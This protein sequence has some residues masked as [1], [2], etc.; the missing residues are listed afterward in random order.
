[1]PRAR[2]LQAGA[3]TRTDPV[4]SRWIVQN[5]LH[6]DRTT[7]VWSASDHAL[8]WCRDFAVHLAAGQPFGTV[9]PPRP[10]RVAFC[11]VRDDVQ[12]DLVRL[13]EQTGLT[14]A[15]R[16]A[17]HRIRFAPWGELAEPT[18]L[19]RV[20]R[21]NNSEVL[22]AECGR[23]ALAAVR[24]WLGDLSL[25]IITPCGDPLPDDAT[26]IILRLADDGKTFQIS[27]AQNGK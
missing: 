7:H 8:G 6:E 2:G 5:I 11:T 4:F 17:I 22:V 14:P 23:A 12:D 27:E 18:E 24:K 16:F 21:A 19:A 26:A 3:I 20:L 10:L 15:Y 9:R 25:P 13:I 1:M